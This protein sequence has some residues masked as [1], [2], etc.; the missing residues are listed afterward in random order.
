[1]SRDLPGLFLVHIKSFREKWEHLL[2]LP[3]GYH[4][5]YTV[6]SITYII[7]AVGNFEITEIK[8]KETSTIFTLFNFTTN[9]KFNNIQACFS[10]LS[11]AIK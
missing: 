5:F 4:K 1:M 7:S 6:K 11:G 10:Y 8:R 2:L 9:K 3:G